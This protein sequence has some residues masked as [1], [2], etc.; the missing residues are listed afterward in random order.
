MLCA[1]KGDAQQVHLAQQCGASG[2]HSLSKPISFR[3]FF[4]FDTEL[5]THEM[6]IASRGITFGWR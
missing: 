4:G 1:K 2:A 5:N 3:A 6:L